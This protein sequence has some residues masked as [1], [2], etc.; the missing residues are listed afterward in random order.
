MKNTT[1]AVLLAMVIIS[2][3]AIAS[4][5]AIKPTLWGKAPAMETDSSFYGGVSGRVTTPNN[6]GLSNAFV[7]IVNATNTS[8][9]FYIGQ[10]DSQGY[11]TFAGINNTWDGAVYQQYYKMY[12]NHSLFGEGLSNA[13]IVEFNSTAA[14]NVI[15]NPLPAHIKIY[16]ERNNV[17]AD[18]SDSVKVWAYVT[19]ALNN[20][21]AD[22]TM[23]DLIINNGQIYD[24]TYN[25][26]WSEQS[27]QVRSVGT[28][29]G[30]ANAT[31]GFVPEINDGGM[32]NA[33]NNSTL[34]AAYQGDRSINDTTK[35]FFQPTVVSWFG[36]VMD[37]YGKPYG[38]VK[39]T[40]HI[41]GTLN[42]VPGSEI[43]TINTTALPDQPYPGSCVF[44]NIIMWNN[45][46]HAYDCAGNHSGWVIITGASNNYSLNK[47]RDLRWLHCAARPAAGCIKVIANPDTILVGGDT[48]SSPHSCT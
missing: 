40:L 24:A 13:F 25:G 20:P 12:A 45:V 8:Q 44:D 16:S 36:S 19:D 46:T 4:A 43:Y 3:I 10:A 35:I 9:A 30:Y 1:K 39:V 15:I 21:V 47:S 28:I 42:G 32:N 27:G 18:G 22:N 2:I 33:G 11:F 48:R 17:V 29:G 31:F 26:S 37:S 5:S 38:G 7:A 23:I 34:M 14:A 41:M 6:T